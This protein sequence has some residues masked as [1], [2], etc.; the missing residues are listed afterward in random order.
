MRDGYW[1]PMF[2]QAGTK[3]M[4]QFLGLQKMSRLQLVLMIHLQGSQNGI[5]THLTV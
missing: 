1:V 5:F 4:T 2:E 3:R